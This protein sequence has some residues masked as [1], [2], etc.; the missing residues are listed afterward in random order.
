MP[1]LAAGEHERMIVGDAIKPGAQPRVRLEAVERLERGEKRRLHQLLGIGVVAHDPYGDAVHAVHMCLEEPLEG[2]RI[3]V[4]Q[5]G[6]Q[7][8]LRGLR[9]VIYL[10]GH[11]LRP[12][13]VGDSGPHAL[14]WPGRGGRTCTRRPHRAVTFRPLVHLTSRSAWPRARACP[15]IILHKRQREEREARKDTHGDCSERRRARPRSP[16]HRRPG[17]RHRRLHAAGRR[18]ADRRRRRRRDFAADWRRRVLPAL[19]AAS[20]QHARTCRVD[21]GTTV[22]NVTGM[23]QSG[24]ACDL[25][26]EPMTPNRGASAA[27]RTPARLC[28]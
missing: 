2:P 1:A 11:A 7:L 23:R 28:A 19:R 9:G 27:S 14:S 4:L 24:G 3:V 5:R 22:G 25:A 8:S 16:H 15:A 21:G 13:R 26:S 17:A 20:H 6:Q 18:L 12:V 10:V